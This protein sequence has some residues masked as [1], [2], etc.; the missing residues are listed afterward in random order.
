MTISVNG[1]ITSK[2]SVLDRGL[3]YGD[4]VFETCRLIDGKLSLFSLHAD[5]LLS[6]CER[7]NIPFSRNQLL[8]YL[9][10]HLNHSDQGYDPLCVCKIIVTRGAGGRGY[11]MDLD[12]QPTCIISVSSFP[13]ELP[14]PAVKLYAGHQRISSSA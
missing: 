12:A 9:D 2:I 1:E 6:S 14:L 5:R 4:G 3:S 10:Q 13:Y 8:S 11:Q 7:L